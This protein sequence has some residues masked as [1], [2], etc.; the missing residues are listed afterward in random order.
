[1]FQLGPLSIPYERFFLLLAILALGA[2]SEIIAFHKGNKNISAWGWNVGFVA[3]IAARVVFII[4]HLN[5][6]L[7][8]PLT[9]LYIW[10]G[11]FHLIGGILGG[12]IYTLWFFRKQPRLISNLALPVM[13]VVG[14]LLASLLFTPNTANAKT[15]PSLELYT[16]D[17]MPTLLRSYIGKPL[18]VNVWATWC[19]PC[20]REMPMLQEVAKLNPEVSFLLINQGE[21]AQKVQAYFESITLEPQ[22]VLLDP[23]QHYSQYQGVVG[24]P[25]TYFYNAEGLQVDAS[26]GELSR[27]TLNDHLKRIRNNNLQ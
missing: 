15:L 24:Y 25:S 19:L 12:V 11:G 21:D 1:M 4:T 22:H 20:R 6:F 23:N 8:K 27:A 10:Q 3:L 9:M 16:L 14:V 18:V 7:P 2:S 26:Y 13:G 5:D 17:N